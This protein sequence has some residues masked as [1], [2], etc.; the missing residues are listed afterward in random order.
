MKFS[1]GTWVLIA[2]IAGSGM[3]F[4]DGT[5]VNVALPT[6]QADLHGD[7]STL[8]WVIEGYTLFL[9][10]L[11]LV[12]GSLGDFYGRRAMFL[13]GIGV[14]AAASLGCALAQNIVE[15]N[16][17]RCIQGAGA[18]FAT[19]G[20]LALIG[21]SFQ[22][23][24]RGHAI[25]TWSGFAAITAAIGPLLG[26]WL[27]EHAS[28]RYVFLINIPLAAAIFAIA[29]L[30][31]PES[32]DENAS[33]AVDITGAALAIGALGA[34]TYAL[35]R[36]Q[37]SRDATAVGAVAAG[38]IL[39]SAFLAWES[40]AK[41]PMVPLG[42]FRSFTFSGS[43]AYTF[44][45][46]AALGGSL[47]FVPFDLQ[48]VQ[49]YSPSASGAAILPFIA[50]MFLASRWSGGLVGT[51]GARIPLVLGAIIAGFGF[52][53]Y[54]R[55]GIGGSYWTTFFPAAVVLGVGGA[56]FVAPLTTTVMNAV[57]PAHVGLASGFNN[58]VSRVA[59]LLAI[60]ALGIVLATTLYG[61][62]DARAQSL[63][64]SGSAR[65]TLGHERGSLATGKAP[66]GVP[67]A[68]RPRIDRALRE[69]YTA[70]F[71]RTMEISTL[72]C[73]IAAGIALFTIRTFPDRRST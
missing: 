68:E 45:L 59:G 5:A 52:L 39:L 32:R 67:A 57:S 6:I 41:D 49:G 62:F 38:V 30:R 27:A 3:T 55:T 11:I 15:L 53:A 51:I 50:I 18:A 17:A 70:G 14:F 71:A 7:A 25:G 33:H 1:S 35:I 8:Q 36:L 40:R 66:S 58:A 43:N 23:A 60:A 19:P 28:W 29:L 61:T 10:A 65:Q 34:L 69:A 16:I 54:A 20:S 48:N 64:L 12:G 42:L 24:Q 37:S 44:F 9:S 73:W 22:G 4:I 47:F 46:Y 2:A 26:G 21:A 72:L 31:V 63:G 13:A 56:L